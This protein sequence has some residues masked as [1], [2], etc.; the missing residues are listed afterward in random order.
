[1]DPKHVF[2]IKCVKKPEKTGKA[3][4]K[5]CSFC[6]YPL[7][8]I[9]LNQNFTMHRRLGYGTKYDGDALELRLCC[10]CMEAIIDACA[11]SPVRPFYQ[12]ST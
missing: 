8:I 6:G 7:S 3:R 12:T 11:V 2:V 4:P 1:M 5:R 10:T 9:D